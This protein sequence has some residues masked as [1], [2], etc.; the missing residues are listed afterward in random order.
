MND[1]LG[2]LIRRAQGEDSSV[3][4]AILPAFP[5][6]WGLE[7][8]HERPAS[9]P[10]HRPPAPVPATGEQVREQASPP[11]EPPL[12][13]RPELSTPQEREVHHFHREHVSA[14]RDSWISNR[15]LDVLHSDEAPAW[16]VSR[17][18]HPLPTA[19]ARTR[20]SREPGNERP[21][22]APP[23][24]GVP[25]AAPVPTGEGETI[26]ISIGRVE[27][28][29]VAPPPPVSRLPRAVQRTAPSLEE[30]LRAR[31]GGNNR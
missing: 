5:P 17:E 13:G 19:E 18:P 23:A 8:S 24:P 1:Y 4:P 27:V 22:P 3:R 9:P 26:Q 15:G 30:Y 20:P 12:T 6:D 28:R 25:R 29:A 16:Q 2:T 31:S 10:G 14:E 7:A 11:P 21:E